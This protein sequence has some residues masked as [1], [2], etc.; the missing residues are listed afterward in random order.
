MTSFS[1]KTG[2]PLIRK[3]LRLQSCSKELSPRNRR[4]DS[5]HAL[6]RRK[7]AFDQSTSRHR[8]GWFVQTILGAGSA[9]GGNSRARL[10]SSPCATDRRGPRLFTS[11]SGAD[12][13]YGRALEPASNL[14]VLRPQRRVRS[15]VHLSWVE[16]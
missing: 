15:E 1:G 8:D 4:K 13:P 9:V 2:P 14:V 11:Y 3:R 12:H 16:V 5:S 7:R 10:S 6:K